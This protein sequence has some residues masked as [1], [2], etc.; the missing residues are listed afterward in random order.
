MIKLT[1]FYPFQSWLRVTHE[2]HDDKIVIKQKSPT[3][4]IEY[5]VNYKQIAGV[6]FIAR[7][8]DKHVTTGLLIVGALSLMFIFFRE[9]LYR[10]PAILTFMQVI[11]PL[12][13][14]FSLLGF[15]K[16]SYCTF[17]NSEHGV[18]T[19]A[20]MSYADI[21]DVDSAIEL[22]KQKNPNIYELD[23]SEPFP[24]TKPL[25]ELVEYNL[26]DFMS[27]ST[28][29]FYETELIDYESSLV[30]ESIRAVKY[31]SIRQII[32]A[33]GGN[34]S[35]A[36]ISSYAFLFT[37]ILSGIR[38]L[39]DLPQT[40]DQIILNLFWP[41]ITISTLLSLL[42]Y[43]KKEFVYLVDSENNTLEY[44]AVS[45]NNKEKVERILEFIKSRIP[46]DIQDK[47]VSQKVVAD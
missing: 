30:E 46:E 20:R 7:G 45:R 5:D 40:I 21:T 41:L 2:F 44:T 25:Y 43:F 38:F 9:V 33:R 23:T 13:I 6:E 8:N 10:N 29:R 26:P 35:W 12:A 4:E 14:L 32:R 22:I 28:I 31:D 24:N 36:T 1:S 47:L 17:S 37:F 18:L 3:S 15:R 34:N 42:K 11:F 27:K 39:Y 16:G 19:I